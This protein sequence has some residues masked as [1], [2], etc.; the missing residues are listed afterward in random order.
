[1]RAY[2]GSRRG[3]QGRCRVDV[4]VVT[5]NDS[6]NDG[7][8]N[9]NEISHITN[10]PMKLYDC[11]FLLRDDENGVTLACQRHP[12]DDARPWW[13]HILFIPRACVISVTK[14]GEWNIDA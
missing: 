8:S 11:G 6:W 3:R 7:S 1:M 9:Y 10:G 2:R 14:I 12:E 13:K 5:W 4:V